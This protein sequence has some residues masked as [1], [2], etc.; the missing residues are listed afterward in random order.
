MKSQLLTQQ[1]EELQVEIDRIKFNN[2]DQS[3]IHN[4]STISNNQQTVPELES[5]IQ[6]L[7]R[8]NEILQT[9]TNDRIC[10]KLLFLEQELHEK[11][12]LS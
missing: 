1:N 7:E 3:S 9:S 10:Q 11:T 4:I 8:E 6:L 12:L 2:A 5:R